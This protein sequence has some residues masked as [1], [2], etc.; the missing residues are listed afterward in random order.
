MKGEMKVVKGFV[1]CREHRPEKYKKLWTQM[2]VVIDKCR[3]ENLDIL[4]ID[5]KK[6]FITD[7]HMVGGIGYYCGRNCSLCDVT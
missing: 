6:N 4:S 7:Y 3:K 2:T 1:D 5:V